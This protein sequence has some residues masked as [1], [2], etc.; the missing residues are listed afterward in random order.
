MTVASTSGRRVR[1]L[2]VL[3]MHTSPLAQPGS[4]DAGGM[5]VYVREL[6]TSLA[7]AG[8]VVRVY[9][10]SGRDAPPGP[11]AVEPNLVVVSVR[12]GDPDLPKERLGSV[13]DEFVAGVEADVL[14]TG[15]TDAVHANYWLSAVAG[16]TLARRLEVPL[17]VS[18][19]TLGRVKSAHG[20]AEPA[21]RT[22]AEQRVVDTADV[23][24]AASQ[25]DAADLERHYAADPSRIVLVP[26][27]VQHAFFSPGSRAGARWALGLGEDPHL[28]FVGRIQ[29][30]KGLDLAVGALAELGRSDVRLL[31]IGGPSGPRSSGADPRQQP[32]RRSPIGR[33]GEP[34]RSAAPP[35]PV[36]LLP[37][38][39]RGRGAQPHRELWPGRVGGGIVWPERVGRRCG[40]APW[41]GDP[42]RD[43]P[44]GSGTRPSS[45]GGG[46]R[47]G[48]R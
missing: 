34:D 26:P 35:H 31:A 12:A 23:L 17:A 36:H 39:R 15:G 27:G 45:L 11:V 43:R 7:Q 47:Q 21:A 5:N 22:L 33:P 29:P 4:A 40:R 14:A 32:D 13:V 46:H 1:R 38:R 42:R 20:D 2:C 16:R 48:A 44:P 3:S 10:R 28:L 18:F 9:T 41:A 30:L 37:G 6:A 8:V 19:H 24:C 25:S